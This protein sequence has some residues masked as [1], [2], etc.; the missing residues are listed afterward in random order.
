[1]DNGQQVEQLS[2]GQQVV[3]SKKR[4]IGLVTE[5]AADAENLQQVV[6]VGRGN[7]SSIIYLCCAISLC[8]LIKV[9]C[10]LYTIILFVE[11]IW[12][13]NDAPNALDVLIRRPSVKQLVNANPKEFDYVEYWKKAT[14]SNCIIC[15][16]IFAIYGTK[17]LQQSHKHNNYK[18]KLD[19]STYYF[20]YKN[21]HSSNVNYYIPIV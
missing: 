19:G 16:I 13:S 21:F 20:V 5:F 14:G 7:I 4:K 8:N 15:F 2:R 11:R 3:A 9:F 12:L 1:M 10:W 17:K 6:A 18:D